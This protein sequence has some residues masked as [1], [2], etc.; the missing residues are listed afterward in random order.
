MRSVTRDAPLSEVQKKTKIPDENP[1]PLCWGPMPGPG[2]RSL[3]GG[4]VAPPSSEFDTFSDSKTYFRTFRAWKQFI[5]VTY[6]VL[7]SL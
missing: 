4:F 5:L 3:I 2:G 6:N 1:G 7:E